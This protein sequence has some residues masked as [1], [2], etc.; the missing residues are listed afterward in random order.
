MSSPTDVLACVDLSPAS[1]TV[2]VEAARLARGLGARLHILHAAAP[3]PEFVG[4]DEPGGPSDR[5]HR[6]GE[7]RDEHG[8]LGDLAASVADGDLDVTPLLVM[9]TTVDVIRE[10]ADRHESALIVV[11]SHGHGALHRLLVGSTTNKLLRT[12]GRP[13]VVVPAVDRED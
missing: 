2:V 3:E 6:A 10:E 5:D 4:Y 13:V 1:A 12:A 9:G 7:L 8:H 11:G